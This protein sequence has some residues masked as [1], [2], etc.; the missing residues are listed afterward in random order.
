MGY[1]GV[2]TQLLT[3]WDIQVFFDQ[4]AGLSSSL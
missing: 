4:F 3:F 1:I 2:T